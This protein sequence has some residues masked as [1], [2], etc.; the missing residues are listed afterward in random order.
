MKI[1]RLN[2]PSSHA[3]DFDPEALAFRSRH[4]V[5]L[6]LSLVPFQSYFKLK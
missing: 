1:I 4:I 5:Y 2:Y 6:T 3:L